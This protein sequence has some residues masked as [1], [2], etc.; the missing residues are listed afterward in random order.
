LQ[1]E[2]KIALAK[3]QV[4]NLEFSDF[5]SDVIIDHRIWRLSNATVQSAGGSIE[6]V[7]TI[8]DKPDSLAFNVMP[9]IQAV[10]VSTFLKWFD[11]SNTD[12]T[13]RVNLTGNLESIGKDAA[14]RKKNLNGSFSL[15]IEDGTIHRLRILVQLLNLLDLSRW[16]TLKLPD[17]TKQGIRFR[18]ITGDFQVND[19]VYSTENLVVDSDDLRMTGAGK[20][21]VPKHEID[22]IVAVRPF[23]GIDTAINYIPLIGRGIAAIKNSLLV[24]SFNI[25]GSIDNPTIVPAPLS[26][27]SEWFLGVLGIPKNMLGPSGDGKNKKDETANERVKEAPEES[28][29][30]QGP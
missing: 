4:K 26:T 18:K 20:I 27:L 17:L 11:I 15:I 16:F 8:A 22:F 25:S 12:M 21:D 2:G 1:A 10:P 30:A 28:S 14:E 6:G 13:G 19:G 23:A 7:A 24:A 29:S 9:K 5:R 3:G